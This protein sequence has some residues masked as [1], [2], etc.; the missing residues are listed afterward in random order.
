MKKLIAVSA[1]TSALMVPMFASAATTA[2]LKLIGTITPAACV[3]NFTGGSTIDYG[4]IPANTLNVAVQTNLPEKNTTLA[5][6]CESAVKFAIRRTDDRSAS[7]ASGV[8]I[9]GRGETYMSGLGDA[10]NGAKIGA[11]T[12]RVS[13]EVSDTGTVSR[14]FSQDEGAVWFKSAAANSYLANGDILGFGVDTSSDTPSAHKSITVDLKVNASI[15][16]ANT[17]PLNDE[18]KID[19]LGSF[20]VVYL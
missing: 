16:P 20:E 19:G 15:A 11:Y 12:L 6:V 9:A 7:K 1:V 2:E 18:I 8:A 13:N 10:E 5:V 17:L 4:T 3:P 14:L